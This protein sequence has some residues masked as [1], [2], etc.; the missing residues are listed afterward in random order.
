M[1]PGPKILRVCVVGCGLTGSTLVSRLLSS[2]PTDLHIDIFDQGYGPGG[3]LS[4][5][6]LN[7]GTAEEIVVDHGCQFI[8]SD[9]SFTKDLFATWVTQGWL[10]EWTPK[11]PTEATTGSS[12]SRPS[13]SFFGFPSLPPFYH[14]TSSQGISSLVHKQVDGWDERATLSTQTRVTSVTHTPSSSN[15]WCVT[16]LCGKNAIHDTANSDLAAAPLTATS[17]YDIVV[18][19]DVSSTTF[20]SWHRASAMASSSSSSSDQQPLPEE[21]IEN[22][23]ARVNSRTPLFSSIIVFDTPLQFDSDAVTFADDESLWF[24]S[25]ASSKTSSPDSKDAWVL[26]CNPSFGCAEIKRVPMQTDDGKFIPQ[27]KKYLTNGPCKVMADSF[28]SY[29]KDQNVT[30][31]PIVQ[32]DGQRW[33]SAMPGDKATPPN[34]PTKETLKG[35]LY[36]SATQTLAPTSLLP[37]PHSSLPPFVSHPL[38]LYQAGDF[39]STY[40]SGAEAALI[41]ALQ[42]ADDISSRK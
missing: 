26:I 22:V 23:K 28:V 41:S 31:P 30:V 18:F 32:I 42:C 20:G 16:T 24:A 9:T 6:A 34:H 13:S 40:S 38:G 11:N 12:S 21:F 19:T 7:R 10:K 8:R 3:R 35:V 25:R 5:R 1:V 17:F 33:G 29:L 36:D 2:I 27:D 4:S 39:M 37:A 14:P 15:P